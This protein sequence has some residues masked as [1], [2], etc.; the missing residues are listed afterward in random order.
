MDSLAAAR[1]AELWGDEKLLTDA[2]QQRQIQ[3][4]AESEAGGFQPARVDDDLTS[5][6]SAFDSTPALRSLPYRK[7]ASVRSDSTRGGPSRLRT[8][9]HLASRAGKQRRN[10]PGS[11]PTKVTKENMDYWVKRFMDLE[12]LTRNNTLFGAEQAEELRELREDLVFRRAKGLDTDVEMGEGPTKEEFVDWVEKVRSLE[13]NLQENHV[14]LILQ[15]QNKFAELEGVLQEFQKDQTQLR[16]QH[17]TLQQHFRQQETI[18]SQAQAQIDTL[19]RENLTLRNQVFTLEAASSNNSNKIDWLRARYKEITARAP[20]TP[21]VPAS[22]VGS[23]FAPPPQPSRLRTPAAPIEDPMEKMTKA[24]VDALNLRGKQ[25][26]HRRDAP[27]KEPDVFRGQKSNDVHQFISQCENYVSL[28]ASRFPDDKTKILWAAS[29]LQGSAHT[30]WLNYERDMKKP[31]VDGSNYRTWVY[32]VEQLVSTYASQD[33]ARESVRKIENLTYK[34]SIVDY[35]HQ[36]R[37]L[38]TYAQMTGA[39]FMHAVLK[40]LNGDIINRLSLRAGFGGVNGNSAWTDQE[41]LDHL[42]E[43]GQTMES[44][45]N[46]VSAEAASKPAVKPANKGNFSGKDSKSTSQKPTS[47]KDKPSYSKSSNQSKSN[48]DKYPKRFDSWEEATKGVPKEVANARRKNKKCGRC[49]GAHH[50]LHCAKEVVTSSTAAVTIGKRKERTFSDGD[51]DGENE[52]SSKK[53][54]SMADRV[55]GV[56][57]VGLASRI[58]ELDSD[59]ES[60]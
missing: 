14:S 8:Q 37:D 13:G 28:R 1:E 55:S 10:T 7:A 50:T 24:L 15:L 38:N 33:R 5:V 3:Y 46:Y 43:C 49:N 57:A 23:A 11:V 60:C 59:D 40:G 4:P 39:G 19:S 26:T 30:W 6:H 35:I 47:K 56:K 44:L 29:Y 53:S 31:G 51:S 48:S 41:F 34:G 18:L 22:E 2:P 21:S 32:F 9:S 58:Y 45:R 36:V 27:A 52:S 54:R 17:N 16:D 25:E 20:G 42:Q 12:A